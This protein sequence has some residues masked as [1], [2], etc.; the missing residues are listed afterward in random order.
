M[1]S[2]E[3]LKVKYNMKQEEVEELQKKVSFSLHECYVLLIM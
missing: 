2:L 3:E 1:T